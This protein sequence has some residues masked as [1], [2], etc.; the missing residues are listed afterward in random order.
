MR[1]KAC[2]ICRTPTV[3]ER[4]DLFGDEYCRFRNNSDGTCRPWCALSRS[5]N[6]AIKD[7]HGRSDFIRKAIRERANALVFIRSASDSKQNVDCDYSA[8]QFCRNASL[9][10]IVSSKG[11]PCG[12]KGHMSLLLCRH[13]KV[14]VVRYGLAPSR[15]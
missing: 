2:Y 12:R 13:G 1:F 14:F 15:N 6:D 5:S 4:E 3:G 7:L 11:V 9:M 10:V 8:G